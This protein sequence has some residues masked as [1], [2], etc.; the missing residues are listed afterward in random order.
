[1]FGGRAKKPAEAGAA[2]LDSS[3][4]EFLKKAGLVGLGLAAGEV[5]RRAWTAANGLEAE[6]SSERV[7]TMLAEFRSFNEEFESSYGARETLTPAERDQ[8]REEFLHIYGP[9]LDGFI[10]DA[11]AAGRLK[12]AY[13]ELAVFGCHG[14]VY[15]YLAQK[16]AYER[17]QELLP[18][19]NGSQL[20]G[21]AQAKNHLARSLH[22]QVRA[23][24]FLP[25]A[26]DLAG[27]EVDPRLEMADSNLEVADL[28]AAQPG[29]TDPER[30]GA[31]KE[32]IDDPQVRDVL[33]DSDCTL[34]EAYSVI[35]SVVQFQNRHPE[36]I[37]ESS[38]AIAKQ[39]LYKRERFKHAEI[40]GPSTDQFIAF[41]FH[42]P[43][44]QQFDPQLLQDLAD[45]AG[46]YH[47]ARTVIDTSD[48]ERARTQLS[49]ALINARGRTTIYFDTHGSNQ[50]LAISRGPVPESVIDVSELA[51][52]L[53]SNL[54]ASGDPNALKEMR[55]I[56]SSCN[57]Y[58]FTENLVAEM[59]VQY[60]LMGCDGVLNVP[61]DEITLP[62]V[63]TGAQEGS[64]AYSTPTLAAALPAIEKDG[65]FTGEHVL[66]LLQPIDY[67]LTDFTIFEGRPGG[68]EE[69][70][71]LQHTPAS[72]EVPV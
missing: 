50:D 21:L 32:M 23:A 71:A 49:E 57:S 11:D 67:R 35:K 62:S 15:A 8:L 47:D 30:L 52:N 34:A 58:D 53:V 2:P 33:Q 22:F 40:L 6:R 69:I 36:K 20:I 45:A 44:G 68:L 41:T 12:D 72:G 5:G 51:W 46:V 24:D 31:F 61:F 55:I 56:L 66:R 3:R 59:R 1:M 13:T 64:L 16:E 10:A 38:A 17:K 19:K 4:R 28:I 14:R 42:E 48:S 9:E 7:D 29:W 25:H 60:Q 54:A 43:N 39:M 18:K 26:A 70:A 63:I 27:E 65:R 37:L